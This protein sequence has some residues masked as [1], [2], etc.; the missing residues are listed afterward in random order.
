MLT[1]PLATVVADLLPGQGELKRGA[2][3]TGLRN[4]RGDDSM[5]RLI[6][7]M[8]AL[9]VMVPAVV[10]SRLGAHGASRTAFFDPSSQKITVRIEGDVRHPGI[11]SFSANIMTNGAIALA[12]PA[13]WQANPVLK[14]GA[15]SPLASG[16]VLRVS[17]MRDDSFVISV[18]SMST[19]ERVILGLPLDINGMDAADFDRLPGIGPVLA[20]R[21]VEFRQYNGGKMRPDQLMSVKG[22]GL[23]K[24]AVLEKYFN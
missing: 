2:P 24:Y 4:G 1:A 6:V 10:K 12:E 9:A 17:R 5:E 13:R 16:S 11:Y 19:A 22:I 15:L 21:I 23:K 18:G 7:L 3:K 20:A 8:L 14:T